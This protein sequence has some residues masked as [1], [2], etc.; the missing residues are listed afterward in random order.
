MKQEVFSKIFTPLMGVDN[1]VVLA[2]STANDEFNYYTQLLDL[3]TPSG[4]PLFKTLVIQLACRSCRHA[5]RTLYCPHRRHLLPRWKSA[6]RLELMRTIMANTPELYA[7]ENMGAIVSSR[8][9][10]F[11]AQVC[12]YGMRRRCCMTSDENGR[13]RGRHFT[14]RGV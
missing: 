10:L 7:Q 12:I 8:I 1:F 9:F 4:E 13:C 3:K 14:R 6:A 5:G 2:I 11:H